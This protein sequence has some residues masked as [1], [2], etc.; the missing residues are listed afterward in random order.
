MDK[1][2]MVEVL[3][4]ALAMEHACYLRYMT[5]AALV[6]GPY[7][8]SVAARLKEIGQDEA[9]HA[10]KLRDRVVA[11]GGTPTLEVEKAEGMMATE[12]QKILAINIAEEE[13][14]IR[15]YQG[16]LK[17]IPHDQETLL[18]ETVEHILTDEMEH[19]EELSRLK[20]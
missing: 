5:H 12:L 3:N 18:F 6:T 15:M 9:G 14:A 1:K 16:I 17:E 13:S 2:K 20:G 7:A 19:L 10:E 4:K 11:L 8:E